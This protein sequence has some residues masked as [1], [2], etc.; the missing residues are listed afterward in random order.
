[1][2][3]PTLSYDIVQL[4]NDKKT[5]R[6]AT[7]IKDIAEALGLSRNTVS[8]VLNG[9]AVP[10]KTRE[11]VLRKASELNYKAINIEVEQQKKYRILLL[12]GKP[13][14]NFSYYITLVNAVENY[15]LKHHYE[16]FLYS[17]SSEI[18]SLGSIR[19]HLKSLHID[20]IVAIEC[21]DP[22]FITFL[23][24]L[25]IPTCYVDFP[26]VKFDFQDHHDL[27]LCSDQKAVC[28][29]VKSLIQNRRLRRFCFVGDYRHCLSFH[30]RYLGMLRALYRSGIPHSQTSDILDS[31]SAF[32]FGSVD[33]L[34]QRISS[35]KTLP[36]C[37]VC[38][39]DFVAR[40]VA[41]ALLSMGKRIPEDAMVMGF[42]NTYI[43]EGE[44]PAITTFNVDKTYLGILAT[45]TLIDRIEM[46]KSPT[47]TIMVD[48]DLIERESTGK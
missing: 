3:M 46:P 38:C 1:M 35:F 21:F 12:S 34:K 28:E 42:D 16:V 8:K 31:E 14:S 32:D 15:C 25:N 6:K 44:S 5:M 23:C 48:C 36:Q 13:L 30:E 40:M 11:I 29:Y 19:G 45:R 4:K 20:G 2:Q 22:D 41:R 39:N 7:T 33:A 24:G 37:F 26:G 43:S 18:T 17:Y 27:I 47:K 10:E 9:G